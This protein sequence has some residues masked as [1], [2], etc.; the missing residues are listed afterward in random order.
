MGGGTPLVG[1]NP[2]QKLASGKP[3][4]SVNQ[5]TCKTMTQKESIWT[6][7]C[8]GVSVNDQYQGILFK[9]LEHGP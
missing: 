8:V 9:S 4:A 6:N 5:A 7:G 3:T 1:N 2:G